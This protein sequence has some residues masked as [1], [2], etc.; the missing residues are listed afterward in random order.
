MCERMLIFALLVLPAHAGTISYT[1][2]GTFSPS[3]PTT[4]YSGPGKMWAFSFQ[5]DSTPAVSDFQSGIIF[6][7]VFS[8]FSYTL[9]GSP[10]VVTPTSLSFVNAAFGGGFSFCFIATPFPCT[11]LSLPG[12]Q[13]YTG[14]ESAP[15]M[16]TGGFTLNTT[17][18][19]GTL[20]YTQPDT[21]VQ[22]TAL[23]E[24]STLLTLAAGLLAVGVQ[25]RRRNPAT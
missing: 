18:A 3:T 23:P 22:A 2:S 16:L 4:T 17:F 9:D 6:S 10:I 13:M 25:H 11:E 19:V 21:T 7:P 20:L 8:N 24:P 12:T 5:V 1:D 15:T 14:P